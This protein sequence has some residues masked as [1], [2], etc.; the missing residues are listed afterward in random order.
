[1]EPEGQERSSDSAGARDRL[2]RLREATSRIND[3]LALD[4]VLQEVIH[5]ARD[6]TD[7]RYGVIAT[8]GESNQ[9]EDFFT[10]G[11]SA[12]EREALHTNPRGTELWQFFN[13]LPGPLRV[14]DFASHSRALGLPALRGVPV[15]AFMAAPI[16]SQQVGIGNIYLA[17]DADGPEFSREDEDILVMFAAQ[18][19]LVIANARRHRD[20]QRAHARLEALVDTSPIGVALLD[21]RSGVAL[22]LNREAERITEALLMPNRQS[23]DLLHEVTVQRLDGRV[24][25]LIDSPLAEVLGTG[26]TV[27]AEEIVISVPDGRSISTLINATPMRSDDGELETLVVTMQDM[28]GLDELARLR[29]EFLA[30]V[31][32]EL[33]VPL[34]SIKG[35]AATLLQ[36]LSS[37]DPAMMVQFLQ[38]IE[39]QAD[40]MRDL[41]IDLLDA[42]RIETGTLAIKPEATEAPPILDEARNAFLSEHAT[43]R[44]SIEAEPNLP[45]VMADR[46]RIVQ[47]L[48]NLLSNA[49]RRSHDENRIQVSARM[50][51]GYV[52]V[53]VA[54]EGRATTS[55]RLLFP[56]GKYEQLTAGDGQRS[57]DSSSLGLTIC[58]GIVEAHGGRIWAESAESAESADSAEVTRFCFTLPVA[59]SVVPIEDP[60]S[61]ASAELTEFGQTPV[62][63]VD[64]DPQ[65][66]RYVQE[67][68]TQGGYVPAVADDP[69]EALKF[70]RQ[71]R[72]LLVLL[73]L[74]TG[75]SDGIELMKDIL[76]VTEV[77]VIFLSNFGRDELVERAFDAGAVDYVVKPFSPT[78]LLA[79]VRGALTRPM[80]IASREPLEPFE[81]DDLYI[82]YAERRVRI[83]DAPIHLTPTE[84]DLLF[85][86][87]I[88][89]GRVVTFD[90]LLNQVWGRG[91]SGDRGRV[92]TYVKRL[93]R[94]LGEDAER[95]KYI[96]AEPRVGYRMPRVEDI[97]VSA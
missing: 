84:Y 89:A 92:R 97:G 93:R 7:A 6:L 33:H 9:P 13:T 4:E 63:I 50:E 48:G 90:S 43:R 74:M 18:T 94:K 87:S 44:C 54:A 47:V 60:R 55:E 86:L 26:E 49:A 95:P 82:D 17:R 80:V 31:S 20:E 78:E 73:D 27:R 88:H 76:D 91:H 15:K 70:V 56:A 39:S 58:Q 12:E 66:I 16:R 72:P 46:D 30:M 19:A 45:W 25:S 40:L 75:G 42:A 2:S 57:L 5:S 83:G 81:L 29:A 28:T 35:A 11:A 38:I 21:A 62:L 96:F 77:P 41:I 34:T 37:L 14:A 85:E 59:D 24:V 65:T 53:S 67:I 68:L 61:G 8:L 3:N 22:S 52:V 23:E 71:N 1:M 10:S 79:R 64:D 51:G 69:T 36:S 32:R